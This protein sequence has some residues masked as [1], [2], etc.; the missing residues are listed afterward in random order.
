LGGKGKVQVSASL[1][2]EEES[3]LEKEEL[4]LEEKE[5]R[6]FCAQPKASMG[7]EDAEAVE[8]PPLLTLFR[9]RKSDS[10]RRAPNDGKIRVKDCNLGR[11]KVRGAKGGK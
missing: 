8:Y 1:L 9:A 11:Y 5:L 10:A 7:T 3:L 2:Q 6:E 4:P